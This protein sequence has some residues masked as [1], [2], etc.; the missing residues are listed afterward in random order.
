MEK[1]KDAR[2]EMIIAAALRTVEA[3]EEVE[4]YEQQKQK[5][6]FENVTMI[7]EPE[8]MIL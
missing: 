8:Q 1:T 7:K 3:L 2:K 5:I 6:T 4:R